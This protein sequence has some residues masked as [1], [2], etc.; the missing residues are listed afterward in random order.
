MFL[1]WFASVA[2]LPRRV[3]SGL[4]VRFL[5]AERRPRLNRVL[6]ALH[7]APSKTARETISLSAPRPRQL[8]RAKRDLPQRKSLVGGRRE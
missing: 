7:R 3:A 5:F 8:H 2:V 4:A 1:A 6:G